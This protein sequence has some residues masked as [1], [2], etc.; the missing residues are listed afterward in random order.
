MEDVRLAVAAPWGV[1]LDQDVLVL[2]HDDVV[3][4]VRHNHMYGPVLLLWNRLGL[5]AWLDLAVD[6]VLDELA[7]LL[8]GELLLLVERELLVLDRLLDGEGRPLVNLEVQVAGMGAKRLRVDD[9]EVD[10]TLVF[11]CDIFQ[12]LGELRALLR[13]LGEYVRKRDAGLFQRKLISFAKVGENVAELL[14]PM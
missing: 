2:V 9:C 14:T 10:G 11:L 3:V 4:V 5:D 6:K 13:S 12:R 1:E 7:N 8:H